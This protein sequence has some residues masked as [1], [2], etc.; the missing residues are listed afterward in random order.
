MFDRLQRRRHHRNLRLELQQL[1]ERC[2]PALLTSYIATDLVSD[3][4]GVAA[5]ND[6]HLVNGWGIA[7]NPTGGI[8]VS[9]NGA[10]ISDIYT[11]DVGGTALMKA[12]LEVTIPGGA[13]TGQ[14]FNNTSDFVVTKGADSGPATFIFASESGTI[15]GWNF[16]VPSPGPSTAAQLEFQATDG[17]VYKGIALGNNG[18]GNFLYVADFHNAKIAVFDA[19][20]H[21]AT[22]SG[23]FTDPKLP[24]HFAPF[25]VAVIGGKLFV[26]YAKQDAAAH[27]EVAGPGQGF[28]DVFDLNGNFQQRL[29]TRGLLN[30]PWAMVQATP[31]FG[32]FSNA[33]LV[34]NFGDGR[35]H[36][37]NIGTGKFLG[38]LSTGP[39]RPIT[40][41]GLWGL[42]FGNGTV[43][44]DANSLYYAAGP[45]DEA[46]GL[47]GKITANA[48]GTPTV[49]AVVNGTELAV[50][51]SRDNDNI[52]VN[53]ERHD[54]LL[55]V[56]AN[57]QLIGTFDPTTLSTIRINGLAGNDQIFVNPRI[58]ITTT[59]DG[60]A[61]NDF[62]QGGGGNNVLM[63]NIGNDVLFGGAGRDVLIGG[64][65]R[66]VLRGGLGD[67]LLIAGRTNHDADEAALLQLLG[68]WTSTDSY[69]VRVDKLNH[70]IGGLPLLDVTT[71][72]DD[73]TGD[74]LTG[75]DGFDTFFAGADDRVFD[76][77]S[78]EILIVI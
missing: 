50:T 66:D 53:L 67:D 69:A 60:G 42:A 70:G 29:V 21:P 5:L 9:S 48:R 2:V 36:A 8:W 65:G 71:I 77:G 62:I 75:G 31:S 34:G 15:S 4:T 24:A 25:N 73:S 46:D 27:D 49:T 30:A 6:T 41:D 3:Q 19:T 72:T 39:G 78:N 20:F 51:G 57:G 32:D 56:R 33:L 10:G 54:A 63:G 68:E 11:G 38:T 55:T 22:L 76:Q 28:V 74:R 17:A 35:I 40:I 37:Y 59:I 23:S 52:R 12:A 44:G 43:A 45:N 7:V 61:G 16:N 64:D 14:V 47:F 18:T 1:D 26:S 13:P 58:T